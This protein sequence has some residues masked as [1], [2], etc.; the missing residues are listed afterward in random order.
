MSLARLLVCLTLLFLIAGC[1][2]RSATPPGQQAATQPVTTP[3][4]PPPQPAEIAKDAAA[5]AAPP[6]S[7][8]AAETSGEAAADT[9]A[10][11]PAETPAKT[12]NAWGRERFV[13]F[14]PAA[15]LLVEL[16]M[17]ID[18]QPFAD[19]REQLVDDALKLADRDGD[20]RATW[21]EI[22]SDPKRAFAARFDVQTRNVLRKEFLKTY[23]TNQNGLLDRD[24]A[25]R[26][27]SRAKSAGDAFS[28]VGTT[29]YR[30]AN[31]RQSIVR[32]MLDANSDDLLDA[33]ELAGAPERL[34][35]RDANNDHLVSWDE[36]DDSL[37]G[38][39]QAMSARQ[40]A[41]FNQPAALRLGPRASW[42]GII[43]ALAELYLS[44]DEIPNDAPPLLKSLADRLDADHDGRLSYEEARML[45]AV[46]PHLVLAANFG[47][48]GNLLS[49]VS[50]VRA[51]EILGSESDLVSHLPNGLLLRLADYRLQV[52]MDDRQ[53]ADVK[54]TAEAQFEML[55]KDNNSYLEKTEIGDSSPE[56]ARIFDEADTDADGKLYLTELLAYQRR[57]QPQATAIQAV[58]QD[59]QDV[60]FALLDANHDDRLTKRELQAAREV[61]LALDAD[62]D[63]RISLAELPGSMTLWLGRG[64]PSAMSQPKRR[65]AAP[66]SLPAG[67]DWFVFMDE[68]RDQEISLDEFPGTAEKFRALDLNGDGFISLSEAHRTV[69]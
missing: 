24:E 51:A 6:I 50:L 40:D 33:A 31:R 53:G 34:R 61:L 22:Y 49:G 58:A 20:G 52:L 2:R 59:D 13:L 16:Q 11:T 12:D 47:R 37:A 26:I 14:L 35:V 9:P 19:A 56:L 23:D 42:D 39:R 69:D 1:T 32:V 43:Y 65:T 15:P 57:Q 45:G 5:S 46:E 60:L 3:A 18:G 27:V 28:L 62:G 66:P 68:N 30:H 55:D 48:S 29:E 8:E 63:E 64:M 25:R 21:E 36:L 38:D 7:R 10:D 4:A 67:P 41:Y 17:T 44:S 54:T